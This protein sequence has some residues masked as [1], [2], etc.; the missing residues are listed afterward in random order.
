MAGEEAAVVA[1]VV[2][3][4]I[5][6]TTDADKEEAAQMIE[7]H[8]LRTITTLHK[9]VVLSRS[10]DVHARQ[11]MTGLAPRVNADIDRTITLQSATISSSMSGSSMTPKSAIV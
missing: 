5:A 4:I 3:S 7:E 1:G 9:S 8:R 11:H 2:R 6:M 10:A